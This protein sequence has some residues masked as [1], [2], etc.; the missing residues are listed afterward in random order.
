MYAALAAGDY[1]SEW[2]VL[3]PEPDGSL[4]IPPAVWD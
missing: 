1:L 3:I 2:T 4:T